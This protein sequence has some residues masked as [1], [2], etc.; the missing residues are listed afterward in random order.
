MRRLAAAVGVRPVHSRG[1]AP[2]VCLSNGSPRPFQQPM[3]LPRRCSLD[4]CTTALLL[5]FMFPRDRLRLRGTT[6]ALSGIRCCN[7]RERAAV[8]HPATKRL[9]R[10]AARPC[11]AKGPPSC[12]EDAATPVAFFV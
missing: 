9:G 12:L 6:G 11:S 3:R 7:V 8:K 1:D 5:I 4:A 10:A 2:S